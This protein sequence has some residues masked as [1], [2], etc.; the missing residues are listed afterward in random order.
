MLVLSVSKDINSSGNAHALQIA[1]SFY[2]LAVE[3]L[4]QLQFQ[5]SLLQL[6]L[7]TVHFLHPE[8]G[9][10]IIPLP[11]RTMLH[12]SKVE[13]SFSEWCCPVEVQCGTAGE[14]MP[15][16]VA[17]KVY[18]VYSLLGWRPFLQQHAIDLCSTSD[19]L[20]PGDS[21]LKPI[22]SF[23]LC[24][25]LGMLWAFIPVPLFTFQSIFPFTVK[26]VLKLF[27]SIFCLSQLETHCKLR[28]RVNEE[29]FMLVSRKY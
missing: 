22:I 12:S 14:E 11:S 13:C 5:S 19:P 18:L 15:C 28:I 20:W 2:V 27:S 29:I 9:E 23:P 21:F 1:D 4:L 6:Q 7:F 10:Q 26:W 24:S 25:C 17:Q 3:V 8:E 16:W